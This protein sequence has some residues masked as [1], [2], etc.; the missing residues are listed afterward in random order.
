M[1][2]LMILGDL[3]AISRGLRWDVE[4][5]SGACSAAKQIAEGRGPKM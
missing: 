5:A 2:I 4:V 1:I 3:A